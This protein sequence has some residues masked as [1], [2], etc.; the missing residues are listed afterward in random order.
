MQVTA[1]EVAAVCA[2]LAQAPP[3]YKGKE[4]KLPVAVAPQPVSFSHRKHAAAGMRCH[5]CHP[6]AKTKERAGL[7]GTELCMG[8]HVTVKAE[9]PEIQKLARMHSSGKR[10]K[11]VRVY[12][13]PD[14][15]FFSHAVHMRAEEKCVTCH[16][17]VKEREVLAKEVSTSMAACMK[18]HVER[19]ASTECVV[20]HQLSF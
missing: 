13:L 15:V 5:N 17:P 2:L 19:K 6:E 10:V 8:C 18:C 4:E 11:W 9:S 7:P 20:C 1:V 12:K 16:G 14:F 3:A